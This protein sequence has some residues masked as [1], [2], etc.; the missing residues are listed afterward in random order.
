MKKAQRI[1]KAKMARVTQQI[2]RQANK[3]VALLREQLKTVITDNKRLEQELQTVKKQLVSTATELK[4]A[5]VSHVQ[6]KQITQA[7]IKTFHTQIKNVKK[8]KVKHTREE[9]FALYRNNNIMHFIERIRTLGTREEDLPAII[10]IISKWSNE[11]LKRFIR[12][13]SLNHQYYES[14]GAYTGQLD[15]N[16]DD[17]VHLLERVEEWG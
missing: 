15:A 2:N 16:Q 3:E 11:T 8:V 7:K 12:A 17:I 4:R 5:K 1:Q 9:V 13:Y 6:F 14:D 10:E